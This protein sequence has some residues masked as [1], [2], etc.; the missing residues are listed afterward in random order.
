MRARRC[1]QQQLVWLTATGL[2]AVLPL[3][4]LTFPP[5]L[6]HPAR[7]E[8]WPVGDGAHDPR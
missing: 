2:V 5:Y 7:G 6:F 3:V 1:L 8:S 4:M